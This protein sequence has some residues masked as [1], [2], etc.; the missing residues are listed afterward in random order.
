M[1]CCD[2]TAL[3][4]LLA[5]SISNK[6]SVLYSCSDY[7][8]FLPLRNSPLPAGHISQPRQINLKI[9]ALSGG[10]DIAL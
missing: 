1:E 5:I 7:N 2:F 10:T 6:L 4:S 8:L 9:Q 3:H